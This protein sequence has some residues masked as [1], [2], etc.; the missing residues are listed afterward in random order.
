MKSALK[1]LI[2]NISN[3]ND[4][5]NDQIYANNI[6]KNN[7][8][9][10]LTIALIGA[11]TPIFITIIVVIVAVVGPILMAKQYMEDLKNDVSIFFDKVGNVLTLRGWC[12]D[13]DGSCEKKSEQKYYERLDK[14][15][16]QYKKKNVTIDA[17]LI[18]ATMFYG[19]TMSDD[20]FNSED[21]N[22]EKDESAI[23]KIKDLIDGDD[24]HLGDIS[25]LASNMVSGGRLDYTKYR[26]YLIDTY[27]PKRFS[28]MY[29][30]ADKEKAIER[31]ADEIMAFAS[32]E[33]G[34]GS[35]E[36][37]S[38][39]V[40]NTSCPGITISNGT[41]AGTYTLE[42]YIAGV[43]THEVGSGWPDEALKA[44]AVAAR[45][46]ALSYTNNCTKT[47]AN[48]TGAQTFEP[49]KDE[50][51]QAATNDT[52]GM[53]LT[54]NNQVI[55]AEYGAWWGNNPGT[56]CGSYN[57][58]QNGQCSINL[59]K[60][61]NKEPWTFTM[62]QNYF[63]YGNVTNNIQMSDG[64]V[65]ALGGHCRGMTQ[66]GAKYLALGEQ[67][68]YD[69][70]LQTFYSD[71]VEIS[72]FGNNQNSCSQTTSSQ[73]L[74]ASDYK[75]F[76]QRVGNPTRNDYYYSQD[77]FYSSNVGQCVW[78]TQRRALEILNTVEIDE[79]KRKQA[80]QA[81]MN[82][83]GNGRDWWNNPSLKMFGTSTNY[84]EPKVGALIVWRYTN[85][86]IKNM[87][88][89]YGHIGVVEA[90]DYENRTMTV[91]DGWKSNWKNP[92]SIEYASFGFRT[93]PFEWA[94]NYGNPQKYI[95][96]GYV[97]LLD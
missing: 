45:S 80:I 52:A 26:K 51:L 72:T 68:T 54:Y 49:V 66:F 40:I 38:C 39:N 88:A 94:Q 83:T 85:Q 69:Q 79:T 43:L 77:Y 78:Y 18:T 12:S 73:G 60:V 71:G 47:I 59:Y 86:N 63:A 4:K 89:D 19:N 20:K 9:R 34:A 44:Q 50:R 8:V 48:S 61:P 56:S 10:R 3:K 97:Y 67:K 30:E 2:K 7:G 27:I 96:L 95:F 53:V 42:E 70:I 33:D 64:S 29:N 13:K 62:P 6:L 25:V 17:E 57:N 87:G 92:N 36:F 81:I 46:Y 23:E 22:E 5:S 1:K 75:G 58:C 15:V 93:V 55:H 74:I 14:V 37:A 28:D 35:G 32:L 41:Y 16:Q 24:I 84:A 65:Q 76:M 31:I 11:L 91:S 21:D 82:T 90:V